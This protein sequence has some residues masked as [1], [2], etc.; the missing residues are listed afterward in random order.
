M[1]LA[2]SAWLWLGSASPRRVALM[3]ARPVRR[4]AG[5]RSGGWP[6]RLAAGVVGLSLLLLVGGPIGFVLA[7]ASFVLVPRVTGRLESRGTREQRTRLAA[8]APLVADLLSATMAAGSTVRAALVVVSQAVGEPT[9]GA[10]RP[11]V[12]ALDLGA[13]TGTAWALLAHDPSLGPIAQAIQR[14]TE[15]GAPLSSVLARIADDL[16]RRHQSS[17]EVA[18]RSAGVRAVLPLV[19]CFLPA[20]LLLGVV[21]VVAALAGGLLGW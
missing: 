10:V 14:S 13:D 12:A 11:V 6:A 3:T 20:F 9:S 18:A 16:R 2:A 21:P 8:Q 15:S 5:V 1:L 7:A 17:V 19:A 4:E